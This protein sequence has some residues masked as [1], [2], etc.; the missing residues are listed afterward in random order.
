VP[1]NEVCR[2]EP[3]RL[4]AGPGLEGQNLEMLV[5]AEAKH[6]MQR[7][8]GAGGG[9][10]DGGSGGEGYVLHCYICRVGFEVLRL[11][12]LPVC[13]DLDQTVL[14]WH[15]LADAKRHPLD[16]RSEYGLDGVNERCPE[17]VYNALKDAHDKIGDQAAVDK[18][19]KM[20]QDAVNVAK[21]EQKLLQQK[22]NPDTYSLSSKN[23]FIA[24][25]QDEHLLLRFAQKTFLGKD[26]IEIDGRDE[27]IRY[28]PTFGS[29]L[30]CTYLVRDG[31]SRNK[32][33]AVLIKIKP[34]RTGILYLRPH[35]W[36]LLLNDQFDV[37]FATHASPDQAL[38]YLKVAHAS[39]FRTRIDVALGRH[40]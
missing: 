30:G 33:A 26:Q 24:W 14:Y 36:D 3:H 27:A 1:L 16:G 28:G 21:G 17:G 19:L 8:V 23:A 13:L 2:L 34:K 32:H 7:G 39:S 6:D 35:I 38:A 4:W 25:L 20:C 18:A 9:S 37:Y 22:Q 12:K 31:R 11:H 40:T 5:I 10:G 29:G 15:E